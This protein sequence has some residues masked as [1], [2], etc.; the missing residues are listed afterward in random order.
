MADALRRILA[1]TTELDLHAVARDHLCPHRSR[2]A[3]HVDRRHARDLRDLGQPRIG[4]EQAVAADLGHLH[5]RP[6]DLEVVDGS[7]LDRGAQPRARLQP[8]DHV[9]PAPAARAPPLVG[10]VAQLLQL[11]ERGLDD[12]EG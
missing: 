3:V 7:V 12:H 1:D 8:R 6:V 11:V 10:A 5:Q 2:H 4:R 9:E